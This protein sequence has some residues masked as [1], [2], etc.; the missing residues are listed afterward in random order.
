MSNI[1]DGSYQISLMELL[2]ENNELLKAVN[3]FHKT[4][5]IT[6]LW[7]APKYAPEKVKTF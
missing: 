4:S 7:Q 6:E 3:Y 5:S 2:H 1:Y